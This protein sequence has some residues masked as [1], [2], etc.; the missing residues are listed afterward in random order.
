MIAFTGNCISFSDLWI[1]LVS[2]LHFRD[3]YLFCWLFGTVD[4]LIRNCYIGHDGTLNL[5]V[6][7]L[8]FW[9]P[10]DFFR[11]KVFKLKIRQ[12]FFIE[13]W[14]NKMFLLSVCS[15]NYV[16]IWACRSMNLWYLHILFS[17]YPNL[18]SVIKLLYN[19]KRPYKFIICII[20]FH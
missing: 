8:W 12:L 15:N 10:R 4:W 20:T 6:S 7:R 3:C 11:R 5:V 14:W 13:T 2:G 18:K 19:L 1:F 9:T 16:S 17:S